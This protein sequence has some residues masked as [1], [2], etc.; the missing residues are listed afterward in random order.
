MGRAVFTYPEGVVCPDKLNGQFHQRRKAD[1]GF[2]IVGEYE[3]GGTGCC[4]SSMQGHTDTQ[5]GHG[6]LRYACLQEGSG[7]VAFLHAVGMLEEAVSL[8]RVG[9]VG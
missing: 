2:H 3:E 9:Q 1:G 5:A 6:K 4:D 8:V 7:E